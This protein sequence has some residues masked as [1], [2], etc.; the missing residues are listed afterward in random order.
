MSTARMVPDVTGQVS[1]FS[2]RSCLI[3]GRNRRANAFCFGAIQD[4]ELLERV[5][6][7]LR[8]FV[9]V[10]APHVSTELLAHQPL[11]GAR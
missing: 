3:C 6:R 1:G 5:I 4:P 7:Y 9:A 2:P 8:P 10:P 11:D